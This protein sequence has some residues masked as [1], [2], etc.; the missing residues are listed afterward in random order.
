MLLLRAAV[1][2]AW[3]LALWVALGLPALGFALSLRSPPAFPPG[4]A[5]ERLPEGW[6]CG[7]GFRRPVGALTHIHLEGPPVDLGWQHGVLGSP[8]IAALEGELLATAAAHLPSFPLRHLVFG[9]AWL[10]Q[11]GLLERLLPQERSEIAAAAAAHA[12]GDPC[13]ALGPGFPRAL[14]YHA[15]HDLSQRLVDNPLLHTPQVGCLAVAA[16]G[17]D[18]R[19]LVGRIFDF[20]G[21][22]AFDR[23]KEV[24][25]VRPTDGLAFVSVAWGGMA[26]A[27]TGMNEAGLWLSLNAAAGAETRFGGRPVVLAARQVLERC[28]SLDQAVELLRGTPLLVTTAILL[29]SDREGRALVVEAGPGRFALREMGDGPLVLAN[30]LLAPAWAADPVNAQ[31]RQRGTSEARAARAAELLARRSSHDP[32][33]LLELLRDRRGPGDRDLGFGNRGT[34]NAWIAAHLAVADLRDGILWVCE[35]RHGLGVARAFTVAGPADRSPLPAA[36]DLDLWAGAGRAWAAA[37]AEAR[38][39]LARGDL[40]LARAAADAAIQVNPGGWEAW[41]LRAR[42][43]E[44]PAE[45]RR[46]AAQALALDP[47]YAGDREACAAL[48]R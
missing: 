38:D 14:L 6:R 24:L 47:P 21:G 3:L 11:A 33:S 48:G 39:A 22:E 2:C 32:A 10:S 36:A 29:A 13:A 26:G 31:R 25:T 34:I 12:P 43:E 45:R 18:G 37:C 7:A 4:P 16:R 46:L 41:L 23:D 20:E 15:L 9:G 30:H 19:L 35:P 27:V 5:V 40:A 17:A 44:L 28:R 1:A 42:A 8:G